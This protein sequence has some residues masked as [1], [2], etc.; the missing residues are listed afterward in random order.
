MNVW[1]FVDVALLLST[2]PCGLVLLRSR[3]A[4]DWMLAVQ[5]T[6]LIAVL[7]LLVLA[8][9]M[10]RVVGTV[11]FARPP[12][13]GRE[14]KSASKSHE[15][16]EITGSGRKPPV[17][18]L[19][20]AV[21]MVVLP[22]VFGLFGRALATRALAGSERFLNRA[23]YVRSVMDGQPSRPLAAPQ[24]VDTTLRGSVFGIAAAFGAVVLA[25]VDLFKDSFPTRFWRGW[26]PWLARVL[27]ALQKVQSGHVGEYVVWLVL[28][29]I[30]LAGGL[31]I[32]ARR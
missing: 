32:I 22:A 2:V 31:V 21:V 12:G 8:Q 9:A 4:A 20:M 24:Q 7:A 27:A 6:G 23:V 26:K 17:V 25:L 28:G 5:M 13:G 19:T 11:F 3:N 16:R 14:T 1:L 30:M 18:M 15:E 10:K 29:V